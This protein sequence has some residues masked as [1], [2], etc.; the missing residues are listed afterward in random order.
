M[1]ITISTAYAGKEKNVTPAVVSALAELTKAGGGILRF[2]EGEYHFLE[3]GA[4]PLFCAVSNNAAGWK[5]VAFSLRD[6]NG[7]TVDGG[8][9]RF[10]IHGK[11]FPFACVGCRDL[12]IR[13]V[14][15]DRPVSPHVSMTVRNITEEGFDLI[16]D[17]EISPFFVEDGSL[18]F[19]REWGTYSGRERRF[20]LL[21]S[22]RVRTRF[23]F[24]GNCTDSCEGLPVDFMWAR[25]VETADGVR[26]TYTSKEGS[27]PCLYREGERI[28]T[29]V[30]GD[31]ETDLLFFDRCENLRV[32]NVT[33]R[34]AVGMGIIAQLCR[35]VTVDGFCTDYDEAAGGATVSV[36]AMHFVNC[37]GELEITRC[38]I[39]HTGDDVLNVHGVYTR[40]EDATDR[41]LL[42]RIMH[43]EQYG[44]CPY[45]AGDRLRLVDENT[46]EIL[47][48]FTATAASPLTEGG[49][50]LAIEGQLHAPL[51][52]LQNRSVLVENTHRAPDLHLH[53]NEFYRFPCIR[54]SGEGEMLV[55]DN[56]IE[57]AKGGIQLVDLSRFWYESGR[58]RHITLR[59]N[60]LIGLCDL[61][62]VAAP[63][64]IG[65]SGFADGDAPKLHE[66]IEILENEISGDGA[67]A[68]T[69]GGVKDLILEK[70]RRNGAS[71]L[72]ILIDN[73][74]TT[75]IQ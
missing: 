40:A 33:V 19:P 29:Q 74:P 66:R 31:R 30:D 15:F 3:E 52:A 69:A 64:T 54:L 46:L 71:I 24:T 32:E 11:V 39:S 21:S 41:S 14:Y 28:F 27:C 25:A 9:S 61:G 48:Y 2:E 70:N 51:S 23:L 36:D 43:R 34:Q 18:M 1:T 67:Y 68:L 62:S 55:E 56:R 72:P 17:R 5:Q 38:R 57:L 42:C 58:I 47:G 44:F 59:R 65:V 26:L 49:D 6:V 20:I 73:T 7:V 10:V 63:I 35:N 16:I 4:L 13:N 75:V 60:R 50:L 37:D 12:T 8:G 53:H 45:R 22:D